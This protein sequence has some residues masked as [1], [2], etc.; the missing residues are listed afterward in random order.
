MVAQGE[1]SSRALLVFGFAAI[2][3][4]LCLVT[5]DDR[6][7]A[8][9]FAPPTARVVGHV[10]C[11][12]T[13]APARFTT[14]TL[15][16]VP[17]RTAKGKFIE[18]YRLADRPYIYSVMTD[19]DGA[20]AIEQV[21]EGHYYVVADLPGYVSQLSNFTEQE[22]DYP[23]PGT[24]D[25]LDKSLPKVQVEPGQTAEVEIQ[26]QRG[27]ALS[28][29]IRYGDGSP[30]VGLTIQLLRLEKA[31]DK[32]VNPNADAPGVFRPLA[33]NS[34]TDDLGRF[35]IAGLPAGTVVVKCT[36]RQVRWVT[37]WG[38]LGNILAPLKSEVE[39][40]HDFIPEQKLD[41]YSGGDFREKDATP[42]KL[43]S[44]SEVPGADI[45][46]PLDKIYRVSGVVTSLEDGHALN[47]GRVELLYAD[48]GT[49][50]SESKVRFDGTFHFA[51]IPKG[52]Y[53]LSANGSDAVFLDRLGNSRASQGARYYEQ[54]TQPLSVVDR[55]VSDIVVQLKPTS[56]DSQ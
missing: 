43:A 40:E 37:Q 33:A 3:Y 11:A 47:D 52:E 28:G 13:K 53:R 15:R 29:S 18:P 8:Q 25:L 7:F 32:H 54:S 24:L 36:L 34:V 42:I 51:L 5:T 16:P 23:T 55:D 22:L 30:A 12:D 17:A 27:A 39:S 46:I 41:I 45:V 31:K 20:F 9:S 35:R 49:K 10:F 2:C 44:G 56:S 38:S 48:D 19:A 26:L 21:G 50:V 6:A 14:V 1:S 4:A